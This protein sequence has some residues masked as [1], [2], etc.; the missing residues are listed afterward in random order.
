V[1]RI[2]HRD[3]LTKRS[4]EAAHK[5]LGVFFKKATSKEKTE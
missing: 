3:G 4:G 1:Q 5:Y 2:D